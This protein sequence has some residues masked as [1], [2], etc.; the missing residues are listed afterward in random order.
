MVI[1]LVIV[2]KG[3]F[4]KERVVTWVLD[5]TVVPV[6]VNVLG[7]VRVINGVFEMVV[8]PVEVL[9]FEALFVF[10]LVVCCVFEPDELGVFLELCDSDFEARGLAEEDLVVEVTA[11]RV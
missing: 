1:V 6:I 5:I 8:V 9:E 3:E 11:D 7:I 10:V 4:V 2:T